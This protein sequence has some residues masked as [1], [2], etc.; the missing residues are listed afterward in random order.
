MYSL[1]ASFF[2][3]LINSRLYP[4]FSVWYGIDIAKKSMFIILG[5]C[6]KLSFKL[7]AV[8]ATYIHVFCGWGNS[9]NAVSMPMGKKPLQKNLHE[10]KRDENQLKTPIPELQTMQTNAGYKHAC[11]FCTQTQTL[12]QVANFFSSPAVS[13]PVAKD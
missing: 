4:V 8:L 11:F 3:V 12:L 2:V 7:Y 9:D 13:N 1:A 6:V 10:E 5:F